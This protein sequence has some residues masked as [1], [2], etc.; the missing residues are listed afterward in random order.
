MFGVPAEEREAGE[1]VAKIPEAKSPQSGNSYCLL[2]QFLSPHLLPQLLAPVKEVV[3][4]SVWVWVGVGASVC[5]WVGC[6][7]EWGCGWG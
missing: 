7:C 3:G 5:G 2:A 4:A 1:A 6:G